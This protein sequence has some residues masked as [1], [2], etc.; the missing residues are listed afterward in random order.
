MEVRHKEG[1]FFVEIEGKKAVL[2]YSLKDGKMDILHTFTD[3]ELRG[4]GLA[5]ILRDRCGERKGGQQNLLLQV[6]SCV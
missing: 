3:P 1:Q 4:K 6:R 2:D 5:E